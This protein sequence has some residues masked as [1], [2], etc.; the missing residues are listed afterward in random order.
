MGGMVPESGK[1]SALMN[2][3]NIALLWVAAL[4]SVTQPGLAAEPE[5]QVR[6]IDLTA[7]STSAAGRSLIHATEV[8]TSAAAH[9]VGITDSNRTAEL[10][11]TTCDIASGSLGVKLLLSNGEQ[12]D[13]S[14]TLRD[15]PL[16]ARPRMAAVAL[17][18][19]ARAYR[20]T[21]DESGLERTVERNAPSEQSR[22]EAELSP[23]DATPP[24]NTVDS[25]GN[26][27]N[28]AELGFGF[29]VL[30]WPA[31]AAPRLDLG[32]ETSIYKR[33][34]GSIAARGAGSSQQSRLGNVAFY[35]W[36]GEVAVG[37]AIDT[38]ARLSVWGVLALDQVRARGDN[39]Y[40]IE[41]T[42]VTGALITSSLRLKARLPISR[43]WFLGLALD[44]GVILSG[45]EFTAGGENFS[46]LTGLSAASRLSAGYGF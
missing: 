5:A 30:G 32:L 15:V 10:V 25:P 12:T 36:G 45:V 2:S 44:G 14:L 28:Y 4:V 33:L 42:T 18:E 41:G 40:G 19:W 3:L 17:V 1:C 20:Q 13:H 8:E 23:P 38:F 46:S 26:F 34:R 11:I 21:P 43:Q 39:I 35:W 31:L 7:C 24:Q 22:E 27:A 6:Y 9:E 37:A 29:Q 16:V